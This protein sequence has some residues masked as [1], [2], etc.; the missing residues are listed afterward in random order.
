MK[1]TL[2]KQSLYFEMWDYPDG[3]L[4]IHVEVVECLVNNYPP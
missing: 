1:Q 4:R 3:G 2:L